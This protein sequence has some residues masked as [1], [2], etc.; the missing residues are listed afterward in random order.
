[1]R[2]VY[3]TPRVSDRGGILTRTFGCACH[4]SVE[5]PGL[6]IETSH[7]A[8]TGTTGTETQGESKP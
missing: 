8:G 3:R 5:G 1:M 7:P 2:D 6:F 4:D